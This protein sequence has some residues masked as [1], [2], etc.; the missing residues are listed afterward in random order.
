[1]E[2][3]RM[4]IGGELV[5]ARGGT[6]TPSLDPGTGQPVAE[7]PRGGVEDGAD[8]VAAAHHAFRTWSLRPVEER[9]R[10][11]MELS[12]RISD[13]LR[14]LAVLEARDS[15]GT[16]K[17]TG[18]D[19]FLGA[20]LIRNLA[21]YA[22]QDFPW[23]EEIGAAGNPFSPSRNRVRREP[24]G[25]CVGI[26]PWNF[27]FLMATWKIT[28]ATL[29]G[30][31]VVLKPA[32]NTPLSALALAGIIAESPIP[33]GVIN[34]VS[35]PGGEL[36]EA[37]CSDERVAKIAFTG[38]TEVG[39]RIMTLAAGTIKKTTLELGGKSANIVLDDADLDSAVDGAILGCFL[40]QG[41][42]CTSGT[43]LL[44][45]H[46]RYDE[47]VDAL[48]QRTET[49]KVGYQ[50]DPKSKMG[51]LVSAEQLRTVED[52]VAIG[53]AGGATLVTGG[54][55]V[56]VDGYRDGYY[57]APTIFGDVD[58]EM[59]I[60]Q[61]EIFG[62]VLCVE[63]YRD[64]DEAVALANASPYGLAGGVWSRDVER[65]QR[66]AGLV[67][68]G[69][70]WI[71]DYHVF[72]DLAPFGGY[73]LSG[74][75]RELGHHG[76]AEYTEIKR[77]HIGAEGHPVHRPGNRLL[78]RYPRATS[79][80]WSGPTHLEIGVGRT[81]MA[82]AIVDQRLH[83]RRA[84][85]IS[86]GGVDE[87]GLAD[88]V[89]GALGSL[90]AGEFL[91]VPQ[92]SGLDVIDVCADHGRSVNADCIVALGGGSVLD[93]A[94]GVAVALSDGPSA[95]AID[96]L[97]IQMLGRDPL[98]LLAI[99]TTAGTGSE[100]TNCAV[101]RDADRGRKVYIVDDRIIPPVAILDPQLTV[102]LPPLLTASTGMDAL[103][104]AIEAVVSRQ[105]N[106]ISEGL[107]L[108]AI[109]L[110]SANLPRVIEDPGDL[111]GRVLMQQAATMAGWAF[112][113]AQVGLVHGMSHALG[114]RRGVAHGVG[115]G[116]L[117]PHV[118]RFNQPAA[119]AQ[120]VL[121][122]E[123][124]GCARDGRDDAATALAAADAVAKLLEEIGHP[125]RLR[126]VNV[127]ESDLEACARLAVE[128]LA[129][130]TNPRPVRS[131]AEVVEVYL[132]AM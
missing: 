74:T 113:V 57:Y 68:T 108:Q 123:A 124:L 23:V 98:P 131:P 10:A 112:S 28:M 17:R 26:V 31:T 43:R 61:E 39:R 5:E 30:N 87:A 48:R 86:D 83:G 3:F 56:E 103:T 125:T 70:L 92:D 49:L 38:S 79:F 99:P 76:L 65:A 89:R 27:P 4:L 88:T 80:A 53:R 132:Q 44:I 96:A 72:S 34:I 100:V 62:P 60:A 32:S 52:Y 84:L 1:M 59:R 93:T 119:T 20:R 46:L 37:L 78:L 24:V 106:P 81:A 82:G 71:N 11:L 94:K 16:L 29:M 128:D 25:V 73:K 107:A 40:H 67:R 122:A 109:R 115:N 66:V 51:P 58:N 111:E 15:G 45:P 121:V 22:M 21:R 18:S 75:G 104:H 35:G 101:I 91:E 126:E 55:R 8:A 6:T 36:G 14:E 2:F 13:R 50:L 105:S 54:E 110:I 130:M 95:R 69:T 117:L 12:D 77:V 41:Q 9:A 114:A 118:M 64:E 85:L 120:L 19:V 97:G 7:V 47:I 33:P 129:T 127:P 42:V 63:R 90:L 116:I 102:E